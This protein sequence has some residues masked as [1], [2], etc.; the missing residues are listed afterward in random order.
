M[1]PRKSCSRRV[2]R[3]AFRSRSTIEIDDLP[4]FAVRGHYSSSPYG[5][6]AVRCGPIPRFYDP[7]HVSFCTFSMDC[8][9][10]DGFDRVCQAITNSIIS[11]ITIV[12]FLDMLSIVLAPHHGM[13]PTGFAGIHEGKNTTG[14]VLGI[15]LIAFGGAA[16]ASKSFTYK[17]GWLVMLVSSYI[18][19]HLTECKTCFGIGMMLPRRASFSTSAIAESATFPSLPPESRLLSSASRPD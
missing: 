11:A 14:S 19:L 2:L 7:A 16:M 18:L 9:C 8:I 17:C 13:S 15:A 5:S 6:H 10:H 12:V 3:R 4:C 1:L